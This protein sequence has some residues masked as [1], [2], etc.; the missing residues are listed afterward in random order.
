MTSKASNS[1]LEFHIHPVRA[2][3]PIHEC[4]NIH[5]RNMHELDADAAC[6][7]SLCSSTS[8]IIPRGSMQM[9][10]PSNPGRGSWDVCLGS[11]LEGL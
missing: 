9:A 1:G 8:A 4:H 11:R 10:T 3:G 6:L 2:V 7:R 5:D